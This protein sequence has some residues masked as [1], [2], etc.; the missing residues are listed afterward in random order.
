[1]T[2]LIA[3]SIIYFY[4]FSLFVHFLF[5]FVSSLFFAFL[6]HMS[7]CYVKHKQIN[8]SLVYLFT[9]MVGLA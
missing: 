6:P 5:L 4:S 2:F 7:I 1:M 3:P 8:I 9:Y